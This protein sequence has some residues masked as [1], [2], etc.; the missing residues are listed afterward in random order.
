MFERIGVVHSGVGRMVP[1]GVKLGLKRNT[2]AQLIEAT[3]R[4]AI[5]DTPRL[6]RGEPF[7]MGAPLVRRRRFC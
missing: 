1:Q 3:G 6:A 7:Y 4:R 2:L 5:A